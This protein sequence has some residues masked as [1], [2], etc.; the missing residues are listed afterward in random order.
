MDIP[1]LSA[2]LIDLLEEE[3]PP[4]T[5]EEVGYRLEEGATVGLARD[6]GKIELVEFLRSHL[7]RQIQEQKESSS[8]LL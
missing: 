4:I 6:F 1:M 3:F 8:S 7:D 2:D 5:A